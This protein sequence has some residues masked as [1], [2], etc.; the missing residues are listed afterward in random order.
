VIGVRE[1][2][3]EGEDCGELNRAL[4][5]VVAMLIDLR[6]EES[7]IVLPEAPEE[8]PPPPIVRARVE[9]QAPWRVGGT[10]SARGVL[11]LLPS[12]AI[13]AVVA[14]ALD[15][16]FGLARISLGFFPDSVADLD[17]PSAR[18]LALF[19][20]A[21]FC[22]LEA[23]LGAWTFR[24]C[25]DLELGFVRA[26]ARGLAENATVDRFSF[27]GWLGAETTLDLGS[28]FHA[29]GALRAGT[30]IVR[31]RFVVEEV[32]GGTSLVHED[33][34]VLGAIELGLGVAAP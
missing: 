20:G 33:S 15:P 9:E 14:I 34:P 5:L 8:A 3:V 30:P 12:A 24:G 32:D 7:R 21:G 25:A 2:R 29:F 18:F 6:E 19:G 4:P 13:G 23:A 11:G 1:V 22:P 28:L 31:N 10:A 26:S 27:A 17:G 16:P